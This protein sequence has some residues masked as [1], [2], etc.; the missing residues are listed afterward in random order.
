MKLKFVGADVF[1]DAKR[2]LILY[3]RLS[4]AFKER[5]K[6]QERDRALVIGGTCAS[7]MEMKSIEK[8]C[9]SVVLQR[10]RGHMLKRWDTITEALEYEDFHLLLKQIKRKL[11]EET[12]I[13]LL[14]DFDYRCTV[15]K[16]DHSSNES[17][18]AAVLGIEYEWLVENFGA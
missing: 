11:P 9:R 7:L 15:K 8:F 6:M 16:S 14:E 2:E 3:L 17:F 5:R 12:A 4:Q 1:I 18:A 10:N 13:E